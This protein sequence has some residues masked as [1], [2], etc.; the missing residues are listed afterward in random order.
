MTHEYKICLR[1]KHYF[2]ETVYTIFMLEKPRLDLLKDN[3]E[4]P[5]QLVRA[6]AIR[7]RELNEQY[8]ED[9]EGHPEPLTEA[10][11]EAEAGTLR[12]KK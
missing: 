6:V 7:A 8:R 2:E 1:K 4:S 5:Y 10:L 9:G 11:R 3:F 12:T